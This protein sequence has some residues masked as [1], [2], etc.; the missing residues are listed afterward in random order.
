MAE[1]ARVPALTR[2]A[3]ILQSISNASRPMSLALLTE[4]TGFPKSSVMGICHALA[5]ESLLARGVDRTFAL[6]SRVF[7]LASTA[8]TQSWP[9]H[10][11]GF[12]YPVAESFFVAEIEALHAEADRLG[13]RLHVR[14]AKEDREN[15]S[16][17][18]LELVSLGLDLILIE[19]V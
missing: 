9:I 13:A 12:S 5:D 4:L 14:T 11:I 6:G 18:I 3:V 7:E 19:P 17:Q 2:A 10:D 15:Q 16:R 8:R 1:L